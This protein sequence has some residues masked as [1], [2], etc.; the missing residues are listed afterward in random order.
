MQ[1]RPGDTF[2]LNQSSSIRSGITMATVPRRSS[3]EF[4]ADRPAGSPPAST[5]PRHRQAGCSAGLGRN[6]QRLSGDRHAPKTG[7]RGWLGESWI[8]E[9]AFSS[10]W[11]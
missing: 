3:L 1:D 8:S 11:S 4:T 2:A 5:E 7:I 9:I 10:A 6:F